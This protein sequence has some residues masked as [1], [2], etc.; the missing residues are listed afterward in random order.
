MVF[1]FFYFF[2]ELAKTKIFYCIL[3]KFFCRFKMNSFQVHSQQEFLY[4]PIEI[5]PVKSFQDFAF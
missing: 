2:I 4:T 5:T 1:V 3:T